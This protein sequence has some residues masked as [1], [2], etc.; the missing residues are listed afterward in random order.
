MA[1]RCATN[2]SKKT[3][4]ARQFQMGANAGA[5]FIDVERLAM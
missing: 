5:N 4:Q 2:L 3:P 1:V